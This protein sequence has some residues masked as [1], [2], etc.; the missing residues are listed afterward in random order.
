[1]KTRPPNLNLFWTTCLMEE[2]VRGGVTDICIA[3]GSR[4]SPLAIAAGLQKGLRA[5]VHP[6]ERGLGFFA[7]GLARG[8]GRP[9]AI[10]V[11]SGTAAANLLPAVAEA[12]ASGVPLLILSADRPPELRSRGANQTMDQV[13]LF[14][15]RSR[16]FFDLPCPDAAAPTAMIL[17]TVAYALHRTQ[18]PLPGPVHLNLQFREPLAAVEQS[19]PWRRL[20]RSL[21]AW[22]SSG[23]PWTVWPECDMSPSAAS[24]AGIANAL[25]GAAAGV[26][27]AG[28]MSPDDAAAT[29]LLAAQMKWPVL[30]SC[31]SQMQIGA[32]AS[33][34]VVAPERVL[35]AA[36]DLPPCDAVL[37][38]GGRIVGKRLQ[39]YLDRSRPRVYVQVDPRGLRFD[40]ANLVTH[41]VSCSVAAAASALLA[42][43]P[44]WPNPSSLAAP[45][46]AGASR[47]ARALKRIGGF[48]EL[49]VARELIESLPAGHDVMVG[50]SLPIRLFETVAPVRECS[51][52]IVGN[53]GVSGIDGLIATAA[54]FAQ[55]RRRP[56]A[57]LVGDLS[58]L[59]DMGSLA[60]LRGR[61][62]P[63][64]IVLLNNDGGG[65][66]SLLPVASRAPNFE[67]FFGTPHGMRF[68]HAAA[69]FG[70]EYLAVENARS[71]ARAWKT[72]SASPR[73]GVL[74]VVTSRSATVRAWR[75]FQNAL[76]KP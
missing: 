64:H 58:F 71:F 46:A 23:R 56:L 19:Y 5:H 7:L 21:G 49:A 61:K 14:G 28:E 32:G 48:S 33:D 73:S 15:S 72:L 39:Q 24:A 25:R 47:A 35:A 60:L 29:V 36:D 59:H 52:R 55:A 69:Q 74:E 65:I 45:L 57:L 62:Y 37:H 54:G 17:S 31:L 44:E 43:E 2:L 22:P 63:V 41:A 27:V 3:P 76:Q 4:S 6:D 42:T 50:N 53:R 51:S 9:A 10:V 8:S 75:A 40:P 1:M 67:R 26:I 16:W 12:D 68:S 34:G 18:G 70:F 66:F 20:L 13:H 30:A 11:T 38:V